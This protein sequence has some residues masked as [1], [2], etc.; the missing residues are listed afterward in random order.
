M[1]AES[2]PLSSSQSS[3]FS[4]GAE[5]RDVL[6]AIKKLRQFRGDQSA[7]WPEFV[8]NSALLCKSTFG[9][10]V[11]SDEQGH[12]HCLAQES[13]AEF[14]Q[15]QLDSIWFV[16]LGL[17]TRAEKQ[18]FAYEPL[19]VPLR[20]LQ[21]PVVLAVKLDVPDQH[22]LL[23]LLLDKQRENRFRDALVRCQLI[24]DIPQILYTST[25]LPSAQLP[26]L[27]HY[28]A[29]VVDFTRQL[30]QQQHFGAAAILLVN[31]LAS[32]YQLDRVSLGWQ[33]F[34]YTQLK[35]VSHLDRFEDKTDQCQQLLN[36]FEECLEQDQEIHYRGDCDQQT[37]SQAN[38]SAVVQAHHHY[39][40]S[41]HQ[42]HLLSLPLRN[43][44]QP[45]AVVVCERQKTPLTA[46]ELRVLRLTLD[47]AQPWLSQ[48]HH[49]QKSLLQK[50]KDALQQSTQQWLSPQHSWWKLGG[51]ATALVVMV[52]IFGT[53]PYRVELAATLDTDQVAFISAPYDGH[54]MS[55][56]VQAGDWVAAG[57]KLLRLDDQEL[58]L[59]ESEAYADVQRYAREAEKA[60]AASAYADMRI[61]E[62]RQAQAQAGLQRVSYYLKQ[63][64][65]TAPFAGVVV[66]GD[67]ERLLGAPLGKGDTVFKIAQIDGLYSKLY[68][69]EQDV[70]HLQV[71]QTG[72]L[73]LLSRP[74]QHFAV[75]IIEIIPVAEVR[76]QEGNVFIVKAKLPAEIQ[77]WWRPGMS[78]LAKIDV[79]KRGIFWILTHR[80]NDFFALH[81]WW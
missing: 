81:F 28:L 70:R 79:G 32:R 36:V 20:D 46:D 48:L 50:A 3:G 66:E 59:K 2:T 45:C 34:H 55:V 35:A 42:S 37:N 14:K 22:Q 39:S 33:Q 10:V 25:P 78:G 51:I 56:A 44:H 41:Q 72:Y 71:G 13:S 16:A 21:H 80:I 69:N 15:E 7:F 8:R 40:L 61:A 24:I 18:G 1:L 12:W 77:Q 53:W 9:C 4:H 58:L 54:V 68:V 19:S 67:K 29:N 75:E 43:Q 26:V 60:R 64:T 11:A 5:A 38:Q 52:I 27:G 73:S 63:S 49:Q 57:A 47:Q 23:V 74:N 76:A 31:D 6:Q 30:T 62:A 17:S 65:L